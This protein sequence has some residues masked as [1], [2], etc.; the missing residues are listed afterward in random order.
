MPAKTD[1]ELL[2]LTSRLLSAIGDKDWETY[3][4]LC[5]GSLTCFE[6]EALGQLVEG[7]EFHKYYFDLEGKPAKRNTTLASPHVRMMGNDAAVV[8]YIR[9]IQKLDGGGN[10]VTLAIEETRVWQ[11][12][13]GK[14]KHVHF[15]RSLPTR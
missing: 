12:I 14:W 11:R 6:P 1:S 7:L 15:H 4:Q 13:D 3:A 5:D 10:P 2:A 8:S 9:L